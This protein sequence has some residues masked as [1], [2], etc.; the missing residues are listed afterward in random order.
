MKEPVQTFKKIK[1]IMS[2]CYYSTQRSLV[3]VKPIKSFFHNNAY[4]THAIIVKLIRS[5]HSKENIS[6]ELSITIFANL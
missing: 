6:S 5:H 3:L 4:I 1:V 2:S